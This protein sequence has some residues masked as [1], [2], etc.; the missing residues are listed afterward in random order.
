[1]RARNLCAVALVVCLG[2]AQA[3]AVL[4]VDGNLNDW[5]VTVAD[6]NAST[7][8]FAANI[9]LFGSHVEDQ[10]DTA[11]DT[12]VLGPNRGGQNFD[13]EGMAVALQNNNL[14]VM[15]VTG[16]RPDN[17]AIRYAPGDLR[18]IT[19]LGT[20][21]LELGGGVGGGD[22]SA[23]FEG[24]PGS[25]YT[26]G[27][28]GLST[29][30]AL[31]APLQTAGSLWTNVNWLLDPLPPPGPTQME[32]HGGSSFIGM[33]DYIFTRDTVTTQ[34]SITELSIPL[35]FFNGETIQHIS[36]RPACGN[37]E[38]D[39]S[40]TIPEPVTALLMG[41]GFLPFLRRRRA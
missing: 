20:Y 17:G 7:F 5:G 36:W 11:G 25:T 37:D 40:V 12:G 41:L 31:A 16:Q 3:S 18:I 10:G 33:A 21:G 39:V 9:G 23:I 2:A 13:G 19:N 8:N 15:I 30:H 28:D 34:H 38:L 24:A 29:G 22:G 4:I 1:M 27:A 6:N 32:I 14:F 35:Q 26:I